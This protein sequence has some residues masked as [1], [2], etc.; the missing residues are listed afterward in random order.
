M[1]LRSWNR[2]CSKKSPQVP[3]FLIPTVE[4]VQSIPEVILRLVS[5][6][7]F[8]GIVAWIYRRARSEPPS[9]FTTT[10]VLLAVLIAM[11]TQ[12]IGE[13]VA[14]AFSL[15]GALSIVRFRTVVRDTQDTAYVIFAV[16]VGMAAGTSNLWVAL[17]G[18]VVVGLAAFL[19]KAKPVSEERLHERLPFRLDVRIA[20]DQDVHRLLGPTLGTFFVAWRVVG[21]TTV[22]KG[23]ATEVSYLGTLK[24]EDSI[25]ELVA[26]L[27]L[28][29][30][31]QSVALLR[32]DAGEQGEKSR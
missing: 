12:V 31:V 27:N 6:L 10:L 14:R 1:P 19:M 29:D 15:V 21:A 4:T 11:V 20:I 30:G 28:I 8:G 24:R 22:K 16:A 13:S 26:A 18:V 5:A 7:V 2:W 32:N 3:E 25:H 23:T 9:S 17:A